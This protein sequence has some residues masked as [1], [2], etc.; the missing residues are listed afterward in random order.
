M[1]RAERLLEAHPELALWAE[2][3]CSVHLI[4]YSSPGLETSQAV[5]ELRQLLQSDPRLVECAVGYAV[6]QAIGARYQGLSLFFDPDSLARHLALAGIAAIRGSGLGEIC[7]GDRGR[8]RAGRQ[9]FADVELWLSALVDGGTPQHSHAEAT[10]IANLRGIW[11]RMGGPGEQLSYLRG[12]PWRRISAAAQSEMLIGTAKARLLKAA[13]D[14]T[15]TLGD[16]NQRLE[17]AFALLRWG[18]PHDGVT[19]REAILPP[20]ERK[21]KAEVLGAKGGR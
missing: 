1:R 19:L 13:T 12:L 17:R 2:V 10:R 6:E 11:F 9:R 5:E 3:S 8:W 7:G 14:L 15:G 20:V 4:G 18:N 21:A 16:D